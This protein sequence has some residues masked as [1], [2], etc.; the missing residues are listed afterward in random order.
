MPYGA[1]GGRRGR[2]DDVARW[3]S[4]A[5]H[6]EQSVLVGAQDHGGCCAGRNRGGGGWSS[7]AA[8]NSG[9]APTGSAQNVHRNRFPSFLYKM[10][11]KSLLGH[12]FQFIICKYRFPT[13]S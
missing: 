8:S 2:N 3:R 7:A 12:F 6:A 13:A 5:G 9:D 4:A 11:A 1:G 10:R